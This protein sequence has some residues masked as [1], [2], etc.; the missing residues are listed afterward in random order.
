MVS[1]QRLFNAYLRPR[2]RFQIMSDLHLEVGQQ[3]RVFKIPVEAPYLILAGDIGRLKNYQPYLDFLRRQCECFTMVFLILGNHEFFRTS[4][5]EGLRLARCLEKEPGCKGKLHVMNRNR[6]DLDLSSRIVILGCTLQ[7]RIPPEAKLT[8]QMKVNDFKHI[9][10]WT[11][12]DHISEHQQ[13][14]AWLQRENTE[15]S[16]RRIPA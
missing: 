7:S 16:Q 9:E 8:V 3:Y 5:A 2:T 10:N 12:D 1:L 14:V 13:D 4:H 15:N 11:V 6:I